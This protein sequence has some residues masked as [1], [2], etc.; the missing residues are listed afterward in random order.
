MQRGT[1]SW[2]V[3]VALAG[4]GAG[5]HEPDQSPPRGNTPS[6][7]LSAWANLT[8]SYRTSFELTR[9][10]PDTGTSSPGNNP[11][12]VF[13]V[14]VARPDRMAVQYRLFGPG[15]ASAPAVHLEARFDGDHGLITTGDGPTRIDQR[16]LATSDHPFAEQYTGLR[17][18]VLKGI[19]LTGLVRQILRSYRFDPQPQKVEWDGIQCQ[20]LRGVLPIEQYVD[21]LF[22]DQ[23]DHAYTLL[24]ALQETPPQPTSQMPV[25]IRS[26]LISFQFAYQYSRISEFCIADLGPPLRGLRIGNDK[27]WYQTLRLRSLEEV[28][29]VDPSRFT[30][31]PD[32]LRKAT[33]LGPELRRAH[34]AIDVL[35]GDHALVARARTLL[36]TALATPLDE[37]NAF[38]Q[39]QQELSAALTPPQGPFESELDFVQLTGRGLTTC[40][41][42]DEGALQCWGGRTALP[43]GT[44]GAIQLGRQLC[45]VTVIGG[46]SCSEGGLGQPPA[47][48][49]KGPLKSF[50]VGPFHGCA[51]FSRDGSLLCWGEDHPRTRAPGGHFQ[52]VVAG[53][54]HS[55]GLRRGGQISCWGSG[56]VINT[57]TPEGKFTALSSGV[58]HACAI[59][60][61]RQLHC[62]GENRHGESSP[63]EGGGFV[64]ISTGLRHSCAVRD[65]GTAVCWGEKADGRCEVPPGKYRSVVAMTEHT[66]GLRQRGGTVCWGKN[67]GGQCNVPQNA[68][69][70]NWWP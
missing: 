57:P 68:G 22:T 35:L 67:H 9:R 47:A 49:Q 23:I 21:N 7:R 18:S 41:L 20:T 25:R 13:D 63:P 28:V 43:E 10:A 61:Q 54:D 56:P 51:V 12:N 29:P 52:E 27:V 2:L 55:C 64:Q 37:K 11:L 17:H 1:I 24:R 4:S 39:L 14:V 40:G 65:D 6:E 50:A 30:I 19:E 58:L 5:C 53:A 70:H 60:E 62:W 15:P 66:C 69:Q 32:E 34:D 42:T 3:A 48:L 33:D 38:A 44:L 26:L 46:L 59:D 8:E 45:G 16:S 36:L 31:T